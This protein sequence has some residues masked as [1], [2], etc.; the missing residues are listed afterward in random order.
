MT[1]AWRTTSATSSLRPSSLLVA[2][3]VAWLGAASGC[4]TGA[5]QH[6]QAH[7]GS[8]SGD[9]GFAYLHVPYNIMITEIDGTGRYYPLLEPF[10]RRYKGAII[11]L[12]PG[13]HSA[14]V[15]YHER[16]GYTSRKINVP[17]EVEAGGHYRIEASFTQVNYSPKIAL[18]VVPCPSC[19]E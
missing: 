2:A 10:G 9:G 19:K 17:F 13:E 11:E 1:T 15:I 12:V 5:I 18:D 16:Y 6:Y 4:A 3:G 8:T 7:N 14:A